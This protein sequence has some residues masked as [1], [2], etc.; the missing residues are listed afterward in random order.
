[1]FTSGRELFLTSDYVMEWEGHDSFSPFLPSPFLTSFFS[2][3]LRFNIMRFESSERNSGNYPCPKLLKFSDLRYPSPRVVLLD[4]Q[5]LNL[6]SD[7][8][9]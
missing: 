3:R 5:I 9:D 1:M 8:D 2:N 6:I 7:D 4:F